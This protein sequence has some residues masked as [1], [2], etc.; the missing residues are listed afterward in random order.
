MGPMGS[1]GRNL[2]CQRAWHRWAAP[3]T[4]SGVNLEARQGNVPVWPGVRGAPMPGG[5]GLEAAEREGGENKGIR[6]HAMQGCAC[7]ATSGVTAPG[8]VDRW[9]CPCVQHA[10]SRCWAQA[11]A[12][13]SLSQRSVEVP[14]HPHPTS[15]ETSPSDL[16]CTCEAFAVRRPSVAGG[17]SG[18][19]VCRAMG[20]LAQFAM[21]Q[22]SGCVR[23]SETTIRFVPLCSLC[24]SLSGRQPA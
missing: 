17:V 1:S 9:A 10:P 18:P 13:L 5:R 12:P 23:G 24:H 21:G 22:R 11:N 2:D 8:S 16:R 3:G 15:H 7:V 19:S 14:E 4:L 20:V 6:V